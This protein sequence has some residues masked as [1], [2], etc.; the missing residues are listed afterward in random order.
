MGIERKVLVLTTS[1]KSFILLKPA[2]WKMCSGVYNI[3]YEL[4]G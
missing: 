1:L 4:E 2:A 3:I